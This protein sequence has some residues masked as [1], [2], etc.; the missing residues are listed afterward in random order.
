MGEVVLVRHAATGWT[1]LRYC[2]RSDPPLTDAGAAAADE[3]AAT[4]A[5]GLPAG[6]RIATSPSL[7][8]RATATAIAAL[9]PGAVVEIDPR[10]AEVDF[11]VAEGWTFDQLE[12]AEPAIAR[13]LLAGDL[14]LDWPGGETAAGFAT[15][16]GSAWTDLRG[17]EAPIVVVSHAGPIRLAI[18]LA[19]GTA[20]RDVAVPAPATARTLR[21]R[22]STGS[23]V[24]GGP[25]PGQI[26]ADATI[27]R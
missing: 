5:R 14:E 2:G 6:T 23:T 17:I 3:L 24:S 27:P 8:A 10:W 21:G 19:T 22:R 13:R 15:R 1:G 18:A 25:D 26:G 11:G 9:L 7:R 4:L 16:V 12:R 20:V